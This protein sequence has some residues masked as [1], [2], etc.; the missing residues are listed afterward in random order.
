MR[1]IKYIAAAMLLSLV[2]LNVSPAAVTYSE[3]AAGGKYM[4][5]WDLAWDYIDFDEKKFWDEDKICEDKLTVENNMQ[6]SSGTVVGIKKTDNMYLI[7]CSDNNIVFIDE[8]TKISTQEGS[9]SADDLQIGCRISYVSKLVNQTMPGYAYDVPEI[10][11]R[12]VHGSIIESKTADAD[13]NEA[14]YN[15]Y[16]DGACYIY[17]N[18]EI[19][20]SAFEADERIKEVYILPGV[21]AVGADA[22]ILCR[23]M[24][25]ISFPSTVENIESSTVTLLSEN[26]TT[27]VENPL[28]A[29]T[30]LESIKISD[31]NPSYQS[32]GTDNAILRK[33]DMTLI[34]GC[35]KTVI[36]S[37][38]NKIGRCAFYNCSEL[39]DITLPQSITDISDYVFGNCNRLTQLYISKS[40]KNIGKKAF[41]GCDN[42]VLVIPQETSFGIN[43]DNV[44]FKMEKNTTYLV[45]KYNSNVICGDFDTDNKLTLSDVSAALKFALG[46]ENLSDEQKMY[47]NSDKVSL[48]DTVEFLKSALGISNVTEKSISV[49][50]PASFTAKERIYDSGAITALTEMKDLDKVTAL[51][52]SIYT[53]IPYDDNENIMLYQIKDSDELNI[54]QKLTLMEIFDVSEENFDDYDYYK[55]EFKHGSNYDLDNLRLNL[56]QSGICKLKITTNDESGDKNVSEVILVKIN[57]KSYLNATLL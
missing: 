16:E 48:E 21:T 1:K 34:S 2:T 33:S 27:Q 47:I 49:T 42:V 56:E 14:G 18:G 23:N 28:F 53:T 11:V 20:G 51:S 8:N 31:E 30:S 35:N 39:S 40:V 38:T 37:G 17:G 55:I 44:V 10:F 54:N 26:N 13:N 50:L 22:F 29:C 46:I 52:E 7:Y 9:I 36:P 41:C 3:E 5:K 4:T 12:S 45:S 6:T 43:V 25:S 24:T 19:Q 32:T 15:L 57:K